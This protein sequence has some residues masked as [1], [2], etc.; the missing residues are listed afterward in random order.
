[1]ESNSTKVCV[2]GLWHLGLVTSGCLAELGFDVVAIADNQT[3]CDALNN[4]FLPIYEP[5]LENLISKNIASGKLQFA[6]QEC[7]L[8]SS[9]EFVIL[10]YDTPIDQDDHVNISNLF[11]TAK[12]IAPCLRENA[13]VIINS[14]VPVGTSEKL[15]ETIKSF[16]Q[17][18]INGVAYSPENLRLGQA[19]QRFMHP[20]F[21]VVGTENANVTKHVTQLYSKIDATAVWTNLR[22]AE[23]TKHALNAYLATGI[24]FINEFANISDRVGADTLKVIE[25]LKLDSR[26]SANAPL[27][28]GLGFSGGTLARDVQVLREIA[29]DKKHI[30]SLLDSVIEVNSRQT[31]VVI[32]KFTN[33]IGS[34]EGATIAI[35]GLTYKPDTST[36]RRSVALEIIEKLLAQGAK[37]RAYDP[38]VDK[39]EL[40]KYSGFTFVDDVYSAV[41]GCDAAILATPWPEFRDLDFEEL[42]TPMKQAVILDA[43]NMLDSVKIKHAGFKYIGIGTGDQT[44]QD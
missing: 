13:S 8:I 14:Q 22:T 33:I 23:M 11:D 5:E 3:E 36:L 9:A 16:A 42:K 44:T 40:S 28:P 31:T 34:F 2:F 4:G 18:A 24:S 10:A 41:T 37:I 17:T 30:S 35:L 1:M 27:T 26:I 25:A 32:E 6:T 39:D 38:M 43:H 29:K 7:D 20:D 12:S 15:S 19:I 21:I